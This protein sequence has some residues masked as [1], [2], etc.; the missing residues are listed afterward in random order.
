MVGG[1]QRKPAYTP[2]RPHCRALLNLHV[3]C[4]ACNTSSLHPA[5]QPS[6]TLFMSCTLCR[7]RVPQKWKGKLDAAKRS[8]NALATAEAGDMV[9]LYDSLQLAH[10][11]I[12]NSFYGYVMRKGARWYSMEMAGVVTNTGAKI[13]QHACS[14]VRDDACAGCAVCAVCDGVPVL[15]DRE[16]QTGAWRTWWADEANMS[17]SSSG[18][19]W[20]R[21]CCDDADP[22]CCWRCGCRLSRS[23]S[24]LSWT[25]TASGAACP[26][27][28]QRTLSSKT[29]RP[30]RASRSGVDPREGEGLPLA[31]TGSTNRLAMGGGPTH[32][33]VSAAGKRLAG[34]VA[35]CRVV[36]CWHPAHRLHPCL[37]GWCVLLLLPAVQLPVC[38]AERDGC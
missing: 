14:L 36:C 3:P 20:V 13:I 29:Q 5:E 33:R 25:R 17:S 8:G 2:A 9:V 31:Q 12:L 6:P 30:A 23:A 32:A 1:G 4:T 37:D 10:K 18:P 11:C 28:S 22:V 26:A 24:P 21:W 7:A 27:A 15:P 16:V 35:W 19:A 38:D 34:A